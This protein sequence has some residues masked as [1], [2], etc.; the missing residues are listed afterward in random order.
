[1]AKGVVDGLVTEAVNTGITPQPKP[2]YQWLGKDESWQ[3]EYQ[4]RAYDL[5]EIWGLDFRNFCDS[6]GRQNFYM[7]QA[8][9]FFQWKLE[10]IGLFQILYDNSSTRPLGLSILPIDPGRLMTPTD[11][12]S[13][14]IYDGI[15]LG[16]NGEI[17]KAWILKPDAKSCYGKIDDFI[18]IKATDKK[19]GL[20]NMLFVCDVKNVAEYRQDSIMSSMIKEIKDS[21]DLVDAAVVKT[22][23]LNLWTAFITTEGGPGHGN[24]GNT[25]KDWEDKIQEMEK[26]TMIFGGEG[27]TANFVDNNAPGPGYEIMNDSIV[28]RLGMATGKGSENIKKSYKASFSASQASLENATRVDDG[29]RMILNN[30]FNQPIFASLQYEAAVKGL[31]PVTS[32]DHFK[33]NMYAYTRSE[34]LPPPSR[35]IDNGKAAKA[36]TER[37]NNNTRSFSDIYGGQSK[38]WKVALEQKAIEKQFIKT[39]EAK[40]D[41]KMENE[42][43]DPAQSEEDDGD[44]TAK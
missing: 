42:I 2:M 4:D 6:T 9:A 32:I 17:K 21:N 15:E 40:Y 1:M 30:R 33:A 39:L 16:K 26:G 31:L 8:L 7:M 27:E 25:N 18:Q 14:D 24:N 34:W 37:L 29:D 11:A 13:R 28:G 43:I 23:I 10:G 35:P 36:D 20:P 12:G 38:D 41:I 22:L 19:T 5:F 3:S 44:D